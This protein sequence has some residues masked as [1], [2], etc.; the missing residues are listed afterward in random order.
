MFREMVSGF[1]EDR[2]ATDAKIAELGRLLSQVC[3][4]HAAL[5][6]CTGTSVRVPPLPLLLL[7]LSRALW[8][9]RPSQTSKACMHATTSSSARSSRLR[10][11]SRRCSDVVL[12]LVGSGRAGRV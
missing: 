5:C 10:R 6:V 4:H 7:L 9:H 3:G 8:P 12:C 2:A 11:G 1:E